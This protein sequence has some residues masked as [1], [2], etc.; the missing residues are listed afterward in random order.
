MTRVVKG[1]P[2][3]SRDDFPRAEIEGLA[4]RVAYRCSMPSCRAPTSGPSA[5]R[6]ARVA[7]VGV[8][9]HITAAAPGGP[10]YDPGLSHVERGSTHNA[11]WLCQTHA[12]LVD[13]D[14]LR[15]TAELLRGWRSHAEELAAQEIGIPRPGSPAEVE[16]SRELIPHRTSPLSEEG[17]LHESIDRFL[18]DVGA[19]ASW[20]AHYVLARMTLYELALNALRHG[21]AGSVELES[22]RDRVVLRDSGVRFGLDDL[23]AAGR[24]GR[25]AILF[26]R[27][28]AAGTLDL[29]YTRSPNNE[30]CMLDLVLTRGAGAP[31]SFSIS[32]PG[33]VTLE[34]P[35]NAPSLVDCEE[36]HVYPP[37]YW[38]F[39]DV[40][41]LAGVAGRYLQ[42]RRLV[43]HGI[44]PGSALGRFAQEQIPG[45]RLPD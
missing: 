9:A 18:A 27:R 24:G 12:K 39:S 11:I 19:P 17:D 22:Q 37:R 38:S 4:K 36:V 30:W 16:V 43:I 28:E 29:V 23:L 5:T 41:E 21:G 1:S 7:L 6:S 33:S 44:D 25:A 8:A 3:S 13:D 32:G 14:E 2:L 34:V 26:F 45:A 40:A 42:G 35:A 31:C 10:R 20:G 15:F